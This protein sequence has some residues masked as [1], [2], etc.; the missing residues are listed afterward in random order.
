M[1]S[2]CWWGSPNS[3]SL[4]L[5]VWI[6]ALQIPTKTINPDHQVGLLKTKLDFWWPHQ[7]PN[8]PIQTSLVGWHLEKPKNR[9]LQAALQHGLPGMEIRHTAG[10]GLARYL[11]ATGRAGGRFSASSCGGLVGKTAGFLKTF[12]EPPLVG[13]SFKLN[14]GLLLSPCKRT[15]DHS[16]SLRA[17]EKKP[18]LKPSLVS[19]CRG[20]NSFQGFDLPPFGG[21]KPNPLPGPLKESG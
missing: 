1:F 2:I 7:I 11:L 14:L 20:S 5:V 15:V 6:C 4:Q 19:T 9:L 12:F 8:L 21:W 3:S 10:L 13:F 18:W 17:N 16:K